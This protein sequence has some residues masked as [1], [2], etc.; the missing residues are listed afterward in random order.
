MAKRFRKNIILPYTSEG[1]M[2]Y[3]FLNKIGRH[4]GQFLVWLINNFLESN[5][6][7]SLEDIQA[8]SEEEAKLFSLNKKS[9]L[10]KDVSAQK[11]LTLLSSMLNTNIG[12]MSTSA[13][14]TS[15]SQSMSETIYIDEIESE[16]TE[17]LL[18]DLD[19]DDEESFDDISDLDLSM[20]EA[21]RG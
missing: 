16:A 4:Q 17:S 7:A 10:A 18:D 3:E 6:I 12:S 9:A 8:L 15:T 13:L 5:N 2:A 19:E 14:D 11:M 20:I 1:K 21:F